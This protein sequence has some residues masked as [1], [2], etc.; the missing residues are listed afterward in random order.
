MVDYNINILNPN[1]IQHCFF[2]LKQDDLTAGFA[3]DTS[4]IFGKQYPTERRSINDHQ[5]ESSADDLFLRL[6]L[7]AYL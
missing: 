6:R 2:C 7:A 4:A 1:D 3:F 5:D